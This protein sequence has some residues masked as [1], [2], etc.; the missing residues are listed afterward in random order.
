MKW[1]VSNVPDSTV[2]ALYKE[3]EEDLG[4]QAPGK[5]VRSRRSD[6]YI[7]GALRRLLRRLPRPNRPTLV[8]IVVSMKDLAAQLA[9]LARVPEPTMNYR[10]RRP[11]NL[12]GFSGSMD[13][14]KLP[15][16]ACCNYPHLTA[17]LREDMIF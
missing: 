15:C 4:L 6:G 16:L 12:S 9:R 10:R 13:V 11:L 14:T 3:K 1:P 17:F 7:H 2:F 8:E 5:G